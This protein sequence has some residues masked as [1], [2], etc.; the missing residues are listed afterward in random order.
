MKLNLYYNLMDASG[1]HL[2]KRFPI[3][4][5]FIGMC[6]GGPL[7]FWTLIIMQPRI[8]QLGDPGLV[9]LTG[10]TNSCMAVIGIFVTVG[11]LVHFVF[12]ICS[13]IKDS[14]TW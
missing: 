10:L 3:I 8:L 7:L 11:S 2:R 1:G 9:L 5:G 4:L 6:L 14:R 13:V 12:G